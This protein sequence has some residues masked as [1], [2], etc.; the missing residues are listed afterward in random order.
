M[1]PPMTLAQMTKKRSVSIGLPGPI[2]EI[3]QPG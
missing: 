1:Q 2:R 3:H